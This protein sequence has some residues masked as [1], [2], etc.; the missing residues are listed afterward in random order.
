MKDL[1]DR[2]MAIDAL[3]ERPM[4]W[5][6]SDYE[7][8]Q[9]NQWN[10]DKLAIETVPSAQPEIIRCKECKLLGKSKCAMK[11]EDYDWA[12]PDGYCHL[13]ERREEGEADG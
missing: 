1:I 10:R 8:A 4:V 3:G 7:I 12:E 2:Q 6:D 5:T 13:A 11:W 9:R